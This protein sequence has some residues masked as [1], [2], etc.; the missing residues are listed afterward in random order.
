MK[1]LSLLLV[2]GLIALVAGLWAYP[3]LIS[4]PAANA[5]LPDSGTGKTGGA[6]QPASQRS[7]PG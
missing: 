4:A 6:L 5:A 3:R 1:R 7:H 2:V